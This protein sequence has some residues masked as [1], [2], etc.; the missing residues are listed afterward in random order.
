MKTKI[1][2]Y[3]NVSSAMLAFGMAWALSSAFGEFLLCL[4]SVVTDKVWN[5]QLYYNDIARLIFMSYFEFGNNYLSHSNPAYYCSLYSILSMVQ[6]VFLLPRKRNDC[7]EKIP[8][9]E[10]YAL[11]AVISTLYHSFIFLCPYYI[12]D[13][14]F[15]FKHYLL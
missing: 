11:L 2:K 5:F 7:E 6:A 12:E 3:L 14:I 9:A 8:G 4:L 13:H 15:V 10:Q 1:E